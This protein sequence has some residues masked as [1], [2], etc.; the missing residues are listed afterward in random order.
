MRIG[1]P[2]NQSGFAG[3]LGGSVDQAGMDESPVA[4]VCRDPDFR[5]IALLLLISVVC[6]AAG[7]YAQIVR[8]ANSQ[9]CRSKDGSARRSKLI[10]STPPAMWRSAGRRRGAAAAGKGR[11]PAC[12]AQLLH[13]TFH[14]LHEALHGKQRLAIHRSWL[15][16]RY[17]FSILC[18][19]CQH[20]LE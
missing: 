8:L 15:M 19:G 3:L 10:R 4:R 17:H 18:D 13:D 12:G 16:R 11:T 14:R 5:K 7:T 9:A 1:R 2:V 6:L 20:A